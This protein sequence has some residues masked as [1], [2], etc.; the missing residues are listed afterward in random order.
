MNTKTAFKAVITL[1]IVAIWG[2]NTP[3]MPTPIGTTLLNSELTNFLDKEI[4]Q[5]VSK[6]RTQRHE[7]RIFICPKGLAEIKVVIGSAQNE[8]TKSLYLTHVTMI[9]IKNGDFEIEAKDQGN[10][11]NR[12]NESVVVMAVPY[13]VT[14]SKVSRFSELLGQSW[15]EVYADGRIQVK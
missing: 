3:S 2:C 15:V 4:H 1:V 11:V 8:K 7:K 13:L 14:C 10:P 5:N 9:V 6:A 12:G